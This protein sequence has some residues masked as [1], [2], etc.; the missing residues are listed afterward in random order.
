MQAERGVT[1]PV[2]ACN[3]YLLL[4]NDSLGNFW[5]L[6]DEKVGKTRNY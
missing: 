4:L 6:S 2:K 1:L 3:N 5:E